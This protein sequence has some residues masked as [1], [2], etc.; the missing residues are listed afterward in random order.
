MIVD[1]HPCVRYGISQLINSEG[2]LEAC[3]EAGSYREALDK[4]KS[5]QPDLMIIDL[6]LKDVHGLELIKDV[7]KM[8]PSV[9]ILVLSMHD[10][11]LYAERCISAGANGY[12]MKNDGTEILITAIRKLLKGQLFVSSEIASKMIAAS[13]GHSHSSKKN[14][15]ENLSDRELEIFEL[16]GKGLKTEQIAG[17]LNLSGKT[18]QTYREN[19]KTKLGLSSSSE[20][21]QKAA[22]WFKSLDL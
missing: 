21:S 3:C 15:L 9:L 7:K 22:L 18:I 12:I 8:Y 13:R 17:T 20:L 11:F 14:P 5:T 10:E 16:I 4:I 2:D 1:D 19:I 6:S